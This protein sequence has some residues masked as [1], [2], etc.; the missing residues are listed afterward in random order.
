MSETDYAKLLERAAA[1]YPESWIPEKKGE[2]LVGQFVRLE[3]GRSAFGPVPIAVIAEPNGKL[4]SVWLFHEALRSQMGTAEPQPGDSIAIVY[5][6]KVKAKNPTPGRSETYHSYRVVKDSAE[7][8]GGTVNW[9][10]V[11]GDVY[12]PPV[13]DDTDVDGDSFPFEG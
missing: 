2:S 10:A 7:E 3:P 12:A 13:P 8:E 6:G 5:N 9:G 1:G 11:T 4:R